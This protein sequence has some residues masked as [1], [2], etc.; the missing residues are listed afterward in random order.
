VTTWWAVQDLNLNRF[1]N[2][3][4][5][6]LGESHS[7]LANAHEVAN[8]LKV[9][10]RLRTWAYAILNCTVRS[11]IPHFIPQ[12]I[13]TPPDQSD[14]TGQ[15]FFDSRMIPTPPDQS[16]HMHPSFNPKVPGSRPGRPTEILRKNVK[17]P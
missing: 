4:E 14:T 2:L 1:G 7:K 16:D 3:G 13:P 17:R 5:Q 8:L 11:E 9:S 6:T 12:T 10:L 15:K